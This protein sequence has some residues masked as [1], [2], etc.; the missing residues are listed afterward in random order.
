MT[1]YDIHNA[2]VSA[3]SDLTALDARSVLGLFLGFRARL[4]QDLGKPSRAAEDY[5]ASALRLFPQS[6]LL[7]R[8]AAEIMT[9]V[10]MQ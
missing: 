3:G 9:K 4:W 10:S 1:T 6:R 8:K 7:Q 2:D 5:A